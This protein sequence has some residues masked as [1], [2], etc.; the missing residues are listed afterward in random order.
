MIF[1]QKL[2][3]SKILAKKSTK[4]HQKWGLSLNL[5]VKSLKIVKMTNLT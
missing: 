3:I 2:V 4:N 5:G 1:E